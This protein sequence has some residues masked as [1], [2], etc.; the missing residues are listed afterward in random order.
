MKP[1]SEKTGWEWVAKL[2]VFSNGYWSYTEPVTS[3]SQ[4]Y[5]HATQAFPDYAK[6]GGLAHTH[7]VVGYELDEIFSQDDIDL[8]DQLALRSQRVMWFFL[9]TP[10]NRILAYPASGSPGSKCDGVVISGPP[11]PPGYGGC[12]GPI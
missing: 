6:L 11:L 12:R 1:L 9:G 10:A 2:Y 4:W 8:F 3:Q 5:A 7:V